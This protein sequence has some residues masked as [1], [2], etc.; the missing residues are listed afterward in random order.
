[1]MYVL[2]ILA[3][4]SSVSAFY[5]R[6]PPPEDWRTKTHFDI[7]LIGTLQAIST[8]VYK[9]NMTKSESSALDEFFTNGMIC[10]ILTF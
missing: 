8:Y 2:A 10:I 9:N 1:M 7:T 3:V 6:Q 4:T 5:P